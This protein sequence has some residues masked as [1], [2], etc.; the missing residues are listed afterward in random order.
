MAR[1]PKPIVDRPTTKR[2]GALRALWPFI[3]PYRGLLAAALLALTL[4]A[5]ISLV[6]PLAVRRVVDGFDA[7]AHLLDQYFGAA[8]AI[9]ALLALGTGMRYYLVTRLGER[10]VAD[11]R[12]AV[13]KRVIA[14]SPAFY[15]RVLTGE[16]ISR[17]TTDTTL[18]QSVIGS[19]VSIALRNFL[20]LVG[21]MVMLVWTS[22]KLSGL[23]LLLVP[24][25]VVPIVVL[26][27]RLRKLSRENQDWIAL[28]SGAASESLLSAQTVQAFTQEG[29]TR[30]RFDDVTER[31]FDSALNRVRTR[32]VMTVIVIFLIFSGVLGVLWI[33]ARD[34]RLEMMTVGELVQFVIYAVL[35]AG[36]VG[37]LSEIW[38]ELQR[39]AGATE[40]LTELLTAQD[41]L[42]DPAEPIALP[43]PVKGAI[44]LDD[45]TFH[46]PSRPDRSAL[47]GVTL[48]IQPGETVALVGPSGAGKTTVI[49][50]LLRFWDPDSGT[51]RIDNIDLRDMT[52]A[53]FRQAIALVP[54]DPVIF[55]ATARENI[56]FGRPDA[57]DAE[58]EAAAR[59][60]HADEFLRLLPEGYDSFVG[61]RGV[62]LSGGQKQRIAIARAILRDAPILLLDE[63]TSALDAESERLVQHA[64]D[65][66]ARTR[67]TIII[68]HRL[69]T[70]KKADRIVVFD[71]GRIVA[72]GRH[73]E[74]V[75]QGGLYA[76][77]ARLQ[78]TEGVTEEVA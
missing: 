17:I 28:S 24:L 76:R 13:F 18:I 46:Y 78:F 53:D 12:K 9:V 63:A 64:V 3:L 49:Q 75:T 38:G 14:M 34:V 68:A 50:L 30:A 62:M 65:E 61:E 51:V 77:L 21:G 35:V 44:R 58:V 39:A 59:A 40:R 23:V 57:S 42:T 56:R 73:E 69:A 70:V 47:E 55:A 72:Q 74:L 8:L 27:R 31:S 52:R 43:R 1:A 45:V 26:G 5:G 2:I 6:L 54:Q 4:T 60:A 7:G 25:I 11:I 15:E 41:S 32:T 71:H 36:A 16:I 48:D 10:V 20:I 22:A 29:P 67:T 37:A 33:G 19:S 66:L